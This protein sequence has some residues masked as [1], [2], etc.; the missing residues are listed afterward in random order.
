MYLVVAGPA[1]VGLHISLLNLFLDVLLRHLLRVYF[2]V[3][4]CQVLILRQL[5]GPFCSVVGSSRLSTT[6][7]SET[8]VRWFLVVI[9]IGSFFFLVVA[10]PSRSTLVFV[11]LGFI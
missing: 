6:A 11:V 9:V 2:G 3:V 4:G 1:L 7:T 5:L 8:E 10:P